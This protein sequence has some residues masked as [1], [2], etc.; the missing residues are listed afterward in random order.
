MY[1]KLHCDGCDTQHDT[2]SFSLYDRSSESGRSCLGRQ[3]GVQLCEH[4]H[5][6]WSDIEDHIASWRKRK[7][8]H[9]WD[10]CLDDFGV[11]C[12]DPSHGTRCTVDGTPTWPRA[13]LQTDNECIE[14]VVLTLEWKPHGGVETF[15]LTPGGKMPAPDL[16]WMFRR[17]R[18]GAAGILLPPRPSTRYEPEM[19]CFGSDQC[20]C[21]H[22]EG[23]NTP[24]EAGPSKVSCLPSD[25]NS[26]THCIDHRHKRLFRGRGKGTTVGISKHG[27]AGNSMCLV[28]AYR[29]EVT[30]FRK[31]DGKINPIHGWFHAMDP[32]TYCHP[33]HIFRC[34]DSGCMNYYRRP[35][36]YRCRA[37]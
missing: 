33:Y 19:T 10:A 11:E 2:Q 30:A 23:S 27:R 29:C 9:F 16:R 22:Y 18:K 24:D 4:V 37:G 12:R 20:R 25:D 1:Y 36:S 26:S 5:V 6:Y 28:T 7:P 14:L 21:V 15:T 17:H 34:K 31:T 32:D 35:G 8:R 3:G 13:R